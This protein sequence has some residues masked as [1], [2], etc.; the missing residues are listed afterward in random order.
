M[1]K[2]KVALLLSA[3]AL[4][5]GVTSCT[6]EGTN[7]AATTAPSQATIDS[8]VNV[9]VDS[10]KMVL[11]S[12]NDS[13]INARAVQIADS[14]VAAAK[15]NGGKVPTPPPAKKPNNPSNGGV[16]PAPTPAP[17]PVPEKPK[18]G[19]GD[20]QGSSNQQGSPK[21]VGDRQGSSN[22]GAPKGIGDRQGSK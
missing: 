14:L 17:A 6:Q 11:L 4:T 16:K 7:T 10:I 22:Q 8:I 19:I 9:K 21:G 12:Q 13:L 1:K 2:V 5:V 15:T 3:A 18:P 20:R